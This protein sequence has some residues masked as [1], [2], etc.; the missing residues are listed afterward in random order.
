MAWTGISS[1][2]LPNGMINHNTFKLPFDST[3]NET[4]FP[5]L[6]SHKTKLRLCDI[7]VWDE[8]SM[9]PKKR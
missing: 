5:K 2:L 9:I 3:N 4:L 7:I 8:A 6:E 1:I